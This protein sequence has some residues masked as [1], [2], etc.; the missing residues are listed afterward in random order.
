MRDGTFRS[1]GRNLALIMP[2]LPAPEIERGLYHAAPGDLLAR[3]Q[4]LPDTAGCAM[5]AITSLAS[6]SGLYVE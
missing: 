4:A 5:A 6:C 1:D 2:D 3:L